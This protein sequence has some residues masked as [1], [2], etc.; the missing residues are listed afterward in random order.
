[1][2]SFGLTDNY[3]ILAEQ[4]LT[5]DVKAMVANTVREKPFIEGMEWINEKLV[6]TQG[7]LFY[8]IYRVFQHLFPPHTTH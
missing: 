7:I 5:I 2:H 3:V 1:M 8:Y 4:P 6:N